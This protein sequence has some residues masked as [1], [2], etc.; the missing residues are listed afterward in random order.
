METLLIVVAEYEDWVRLFPL[1]YFTTVTCIVRLWGDR[2]E[3]CCS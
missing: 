3:L 2:L 1:L